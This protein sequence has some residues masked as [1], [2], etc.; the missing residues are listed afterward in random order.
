MNIRK[1]L[2]SFDFALIY[3]A[4]DIDMVWGLNWFGRLGCAKK[5]TLTILY[6]NCWCT[7][8][9]TVRLRNRHLFVDGHCDMIAIWPVHT[10]A[11]EYFCC[12]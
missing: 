9:L 2:R 11:I 1:N 4:I 6:R 3:L 7:K 10:Y 8:L 12:N 5:I